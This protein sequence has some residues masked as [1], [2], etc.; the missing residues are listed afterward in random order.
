MNIMKETVLC[1]GAHGDD[2]EIGMG[3]SIAKYAQEGKRVIGVIFSSGENSSPW[4][5]KEHL[6][7]NRKEEAVEIGEFV[8]CTETVLLNLKDGNLMEEIR[9][10]KVQEKLEV[11][12]QKYKPT[13][14]F[15]HSRLDP[16]KDHQAVHKS[17]VK[18]LEKVDSKG[19]IPTYVYEVWNVVNESGPRMYVDVSKTFSKKIEAMKKF[20]SQWLYVYLLMVPVY[21][22][23]FF[24]GMKHGCWYAE[25]FY[26]IR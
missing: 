6:V 5:K 7:D 25:R 10:K 13:L 3:A 16:H 4:L 15:T 20:K 17:V 19:K 23:A 18:A 14:I 26:K 2:L 12:I 8:G 24:T 22:R 1:F 9:S 21:L 11:I